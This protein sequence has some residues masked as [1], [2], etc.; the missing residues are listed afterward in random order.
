MSLALLNRTGQQMRLPPITAR[1]RRRANA[2]AASEASDVVAVAGKG[3]LEGY[4]TARLRQRALQQAHRLLKRREPARAPPLGV[5]ASRC[6]GSR[7]LVVPFD[8]SRRAEQSLGL[9]AIASRLDRRAPL[10]LRA[11]P[12]R[13]PPL[14]PPPRHRHRGRHCHRHCGRHRHC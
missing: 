4:R 7:T 5:P 9:A 13:G 11:P 1:M 2:S 14:P 6:P 8:P 3:G 12:P 10:P